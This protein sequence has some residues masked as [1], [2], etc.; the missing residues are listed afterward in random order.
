MTGSRERVPR[1]PPRTHA[2]GCVCLLCFKRSAAK[3]D[4]PAPKEDR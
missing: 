3:V 4:P 2:K 1:T